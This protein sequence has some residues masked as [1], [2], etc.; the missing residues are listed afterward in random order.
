[1]HYEGYGKGVYRESAAAASKG[2]DLNAL[3]SSLV[4]Q[5]RMGPKGVTPEANGVLPIANGYKDEPSA[6]NGG[7]AP[8][9]K[10][11]NKPVTNGADG[12]SFDGV[13][14]SNNDGGA[15]K[16]PVVNGKGMPAPPLCSPINFNTVFFRRQS[17]RGSSSTGGTT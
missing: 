11:P 15:V 17:R 2:R 14:E 9:A 7:T 13:P 8:P 6:V 12:W 4:K 3:Y 10:K 1:M 5:N 16:P